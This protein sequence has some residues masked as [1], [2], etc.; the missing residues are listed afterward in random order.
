MKQKALLTHNYEGNMNDKIEQAIFNI[1]AKNKPNSNN[2]AGPWMVY[3]NEVHK[4]V[5]NLERFA[6]NSQAKGCL[7]ATFTFYVDART[8]AKTKAKQYDYF[9]IKDPTAE[10]YP[11]YA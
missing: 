4:E 7:L 1:V 9:V 8:F 5:G 10:K 2:P 11:A 6:E 3:V